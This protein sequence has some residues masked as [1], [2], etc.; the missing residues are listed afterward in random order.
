MYKLG[1]WLNNKALEA[2]NTI[3]RTASD[4]GNKAVEKACN[5]ANAVSKFG[6]NTANQAISRVQNAAA[7]RATNYAIDSAM[8]MS[9]GKETVWKRFK[10]TFNLVKP[11]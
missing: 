9:S 1:N 4:V 11:W 10:R 5:A 6:T 3:S 8:E 2:G 7:E